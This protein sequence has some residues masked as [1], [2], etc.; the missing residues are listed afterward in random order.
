MNGSKRFVVSMS[1]PNKEGTFAQIGVLFQLEDLKEVSEQTGDQVKYICN[2]RVTKRVKL[3]RV[4]NPD[5]WNTRETYL[6]VEGSIIKETD[7][8]QV[9]ALDESDDNDEAPKDAANV[10]DVYSA[11]LGAARSVPSITKE[12]QVLCKS[13][14]NLVEK[15][16]E[17]EEDVR[18]TKASVSSLAIAPGDGEEG[19]WYVHLI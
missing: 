3:H 7:E 2:H 15:Q 5:A 11:L 14:K 18:F 13:F 1:H 10:S 9:A 12:E 6:K 17:L 8:V 16:H 19:L 4:L